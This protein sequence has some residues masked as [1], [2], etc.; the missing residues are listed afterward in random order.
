MISSGEEEE[1]K[2]QVP[3]PGSSYMMKSQGKGANPKM[4]Q[5]LFD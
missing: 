5:D 2:V 3:P 4:M 1:E